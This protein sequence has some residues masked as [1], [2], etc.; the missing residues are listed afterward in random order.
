MVLSIGVAVLDN[1]VNP[2]CQQKTSWNTP[3]AEYKR[4]SFTYIWVPTHTL[5][6]SLTKVTKSITIQHTLTNSSREI[7]R[8]LTVGKIHTRPRLALAVHKTVKTSNNVHIPPSIECSI[9]MTQLQ[10]PIEC[11][12][13]LPK[14]TSHEQDQKPGWETSGHNVGNVMKHN[15]EGE[16]NVITIFGNYNVASWGT[17]RIQTATQ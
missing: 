10:I 1:P 7:D 8:P 11:K 16:V 9:A 14:R 4:L 3:L 2:K 17:Q 12:N 5:S 13:I 15:S 6:C